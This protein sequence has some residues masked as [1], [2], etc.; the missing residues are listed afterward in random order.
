MVRVRARDGRHITGGTALS[1]LIAKTD[2]LVPN[3][4]DARSRTATVAVVV[5]VCSLRGGRP[6]HCPRGTSSPRVVTHLSHIA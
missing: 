2:M 3:A 4:D 1:V 6:Q 5:Q